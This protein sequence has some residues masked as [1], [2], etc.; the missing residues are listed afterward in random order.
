MGHIYETQFRTYI[1][2]YGTHTWD[3]KF[4]S[5]VFG[6]PLPSHFI[7]L[8]QNVGILFETVRNAPAG[9]GR[10]QRLQEFLQDKSFHAPLSTSDRRYRSGSGVVYNSHHHPFCFSAEDTT[11]LHFGPFEDDATGGCQGSSH[12]NLVHIL[13]CAHAYT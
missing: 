3:K 9:L 2:L 12:H 10:Y 6:I 7:L 11:C 13:T 5:S 8:C 4:S 1:Y